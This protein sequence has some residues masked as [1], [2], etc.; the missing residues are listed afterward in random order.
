MFPTPVSNELSI[1]WCFRPVGVLEDFQE[2]VKCTDVRQSFPSL[3]LIRYDLAERR[4]LELRSNVLEFQFLRVLSQVVQ[5]KLVIK[6][7]SHDFRLLFSIM[8][9]A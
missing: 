1:Y 6:T 7:G 8:Q 4:T 2:F 5:L 3:V 9:A